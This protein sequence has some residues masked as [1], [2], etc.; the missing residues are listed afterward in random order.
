MTFYGTPVNIVE[1]FYVHIGV[2]QASQN[3]SKII[4][5][6]RL[7][8]SDAI[9][10]QL[11][12]VTKNSLSGISPLSNRKMFVS[13]HQPTFLY[14]TDTMSINE[15]DLER[16]EV[17]YRKMLKCMM[18]LPDCTPS[19]AVYLCI[20]V[21][22]ATA[23]RDLEILGLLGQLAMCNDEAQNVRAI[24]E[25]TLTFYGINFSGWSG[26]VR[27]TC[28]QYNLPDP[29]QYLQHPWRPDRWRD[30]CKKTIA[31]HWDRKLIQIVADT[32]S[33]FYL[34]TEYIST[35]VPMRLWQLAGLCSD[36][37]R[38]ATV[39]NWMVMGIYFTRELLH[40]MKKVNSA[41]CMGCDR[42]ESENLSHFLLQ[43]SFYQQIRENYLPKLMEINPNISDLFGNEELLMMMILDPLNSK[44][45]ERI[46]KFW[47]SSK[48]AYELSRNFCNNMH[49][50]REKMYAEYDTKS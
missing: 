3:Q 36:S 34:D 10:Y 44:L 33:L 15:T 22:P 21:L 40:K 2:P 27:R 6:Y 30:F 25:S 28:A 8:R 5:D 24:I 41:I 42:S 48:R 29:L 47:T 37:V 20:G 13:Y 19:A 39:V 18:S 23:Q 46:T 35:R 49:R 14:G 26:L 32:P 31:D 43:C 4:V 11:Q 38:A 45:P 50:K 17:K 9:S 16:L 7:E 12:G 1:D